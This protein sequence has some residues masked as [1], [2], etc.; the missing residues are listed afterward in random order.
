MNFSFSDT[1]GLGEIPRVSPPTETPSRDGVGQKLKSTI[2]DHYLAI[3]K[4]G[5]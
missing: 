3:C 1:K 2:F 5:T 4:I